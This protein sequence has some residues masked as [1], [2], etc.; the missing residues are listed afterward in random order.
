MLRLAPGYCAIRWK[1]KAVD[2]AVLEG[3]IEG[4][5]ML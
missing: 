2:E 4:A 5:T 1:K 3:L